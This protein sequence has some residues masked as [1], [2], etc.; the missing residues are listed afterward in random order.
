MKL[1]IVDVDRRS[2]IGA[3]GGA[4]EADQGEEAKKKTHRMDRKRRE[5]EGARSKRRQSDRATKEVRLRVRSY[6]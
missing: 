5:R 4:R 6:V 1:E 3:A 2:R